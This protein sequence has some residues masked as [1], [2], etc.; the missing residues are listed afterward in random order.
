MAAVVSQATLA[1]LAFAQDFEIKPN[2]GNSQKAP[3]A[4]PS[5]N[6]QQPLGWGSSIEVARQARAAQDALNR[7]DYAAA[8]TYA[9]QAAQ[10]A[11]QNTQ[12]WW[13]F[14]YSARLAGKYQVSIDAYQHGLRNQPGSSQGLSGLAQTY[15][16]V[17]R[18]DEAIKMLTSLVDAN[19]KDAGNLAVLG[20]LLLGSDPNRGL[21]YLLRAEN[22]QASA[23]TELLIA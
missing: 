3:Q 4:K 5:A 8:M 19:P 7:G 23:R 9:Q 15:V 16:K 22:A 1:S 11:P 2:Q 20:E 12:L 14:G 10:A 6:N 17:G 18:T 21:E 13:L